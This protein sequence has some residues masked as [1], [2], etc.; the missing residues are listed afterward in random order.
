MIT[1]FM[2]DDHQI[3]RDGLRLLID[4]ADDMT[5]LG[6]AASGEE[7]LQKLATLQPDLILMDIQLPGENGIDV[8]RQI[9]QRYP[10][11]TVLMLTM[12]ED[13]Q[14]VFAAM[15]A[16]AIGYVLKGIQHQ[17]M[18]QTLRIAAAGG[19]V[20]SPSIARQMMRWFEQQP[21]QHSSPTVELPA[22]TQRER[23]VL[24]LLANGDD[25]PTI[26]EKLTLTDKS[27]R[28]YVSQLLKKLAVSD[29][30]AAADKAQQAGIL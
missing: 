6:E 18:L 1:I 14:S 7:A 20:F 30:Y 4:S 29:R 24:V 21:N 13:D 10:D 17:A 23:A 9:K 11:S 3:F 15:R 2:V 19:A 22:L 28:N 25:N 5:L 8:T 16:G 12:F 27:V 26:A